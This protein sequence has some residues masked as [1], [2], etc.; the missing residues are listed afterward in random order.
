MQYTKL[1]G[2]ESKLRQFRGIF[3]RE[4]NPDVVLMIRGQ[5]RPIGP[6]SSQSPTWPPSSWMFKS[7]VNNL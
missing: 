5:V 2:L 1:K 3:G 4:A 7:Q 6:P